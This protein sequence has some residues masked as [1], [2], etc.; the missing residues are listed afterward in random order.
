RAGARGQSPRDRLQQRRLACT[1]WAERADAIAALNR[2]LEV[3]ENRWLCG[4][5]AVA[6][7][8]LLES[9]ELPCHDRCRIETEFERTFDV[10]GGDPLHSFERLDAALRLL[11]LGC[12]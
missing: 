7:R 10:G 5:I 3:G 4:R 6:Q 8:H 1:I 2:P 11:R 12:L 9:D